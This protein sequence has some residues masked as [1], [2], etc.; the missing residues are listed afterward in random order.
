MVIYAPTFRYDGNMDVYTVD[1]ER[2]LKL[3]NSKGGSW[4]MLIRLHPNIAEK[5]DFFEYNEDIINASTYTDMQ[6]LLL[7]SDILITDYSSTVF[8]FSA[9]QKAS[10]IYA[11]DIDEYQSIRGLKQDFFKMPFRVCK[12]NEELLEIMQEY[13]KE[14]AEDVAAKFNEI[15]GSV[16]NGTASKQVVARI[17]QVVEK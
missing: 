9:M 6:E 13:S 2:I 16:D 7:A 3:L 12:T 17:Q 11:T 10:Y 5:A 8:E 15:F 4:K 14:Y 1:C